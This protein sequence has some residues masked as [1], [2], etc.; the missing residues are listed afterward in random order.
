MMNTEKLEALEDYL[1]KPIRTDYGFGE[2]NNNYLEYTRKG[3]RYGQSNTSVAL[4]ALFVSHDSEEIK[5]AYKSNYNKR[6][7]RVILLMINDQAE[8][9]YSAV[10]N[11]LELNSTEWL[12][13]KKVEITNNNNC[14]LN[15]LDDTLNYQNIET[16]PERILKIKP[17]ISK[18]NWEG[19]EFPAGSKDWQKFGKNN[20]TIS[21]NIL[22]LPSNT[23]EICVANKSKY[24]H[25]RK[26]QVNLLNIT[27]G[28]K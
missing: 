1:K 10:K 8:R 12:K 4:N 2:R 21:L 20:D 26:N 24:N 27:N 14:F 7:K 11:L 16:H 18:C 15:A 13:S 3:D 28:N 25:K 6:Q 22:Y 19:V 5:L 23:K 17:D 9:Y